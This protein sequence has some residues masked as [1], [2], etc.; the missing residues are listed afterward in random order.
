[1]VAVIALVIAGCAST[2]TPTPAIEC[3][4]EGGCDGVAAVAWQ[5]LPPGAA[6][7]VIIQGRGLSLHAEV[8]ACY[9]DGGYVLVDVMGP[10][11]GPVDASIRSHGWSDPP[12]R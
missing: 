9:P 1:M 10:E 6:R 7:T 8:H 3:H 12:C 2:P 4:L 11:Q 5:V